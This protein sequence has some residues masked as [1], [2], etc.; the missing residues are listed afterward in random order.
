MEYRI[1][2]YV[3][4]TID[5]KAKAK[6]KEVDYTEQYTSIITKSQENALIVSKALKCFV[7]LVYE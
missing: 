3:G 7:C 6:K 1:G 5:I 2:Y 4:E